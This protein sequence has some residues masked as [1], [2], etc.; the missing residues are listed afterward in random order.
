MP[1]RIIGGKSF[2]ERREIRDAVAYF[3]I[4]INPRDDLSLLRI[5]NVP[6]R[7]IG[8]KTIDR[9]KEYR[10]TTGGTYIEILRDLIPSPA[11]SDKARTG[12]RTFL[13]AYDEARETVEEPGDL[14]NK[15]INYLEKVDYL[16]GLGRIYKKREEALNRRDNVIELLNAAHGFETQ[17]GP[18]LSLLDFL[19]AWSVSISACIS[20][21]ATF[22]A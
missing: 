18:G 4:L 20:S 16:P 6:A 9:I 10:R 5:L 19:E 21:S 17:R 8:D 2:Y 11:I 14:Y 1:Y 3:R 12:I 7:G 13:K 15:M 22:C